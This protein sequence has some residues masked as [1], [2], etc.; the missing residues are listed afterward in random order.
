MVSIQEKRPVGLNG[1][2]S[3]SPGHL[4]KGHNLRY[5]THPSLG[6]ESGSNILLLTPNNGRALRH[7]KALARLPTI[8]KHQVIILGGDLQGSWTGEGAKDA[9]IR[10]LPYQ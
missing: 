3:T 9:N 4:H 10:A 8:L 7:C 2:K 1:S 5:I 6:G